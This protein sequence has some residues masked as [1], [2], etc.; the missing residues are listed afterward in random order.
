[1]HGQALGKARQK[2]RVQVGE[3]EPEW[4]Q[5]GWVDQVEHLPSAGASDHDATTLGWGVGTKHLA[6]NFGACLSLPDHG[7]VLVQIVPG[8]D[9]GPSPAKAR[10]HL[11]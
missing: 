8:D 1:V 4:P 6:G 7:Q 5:N 9:L 3:G 11:I 2:D 10:I